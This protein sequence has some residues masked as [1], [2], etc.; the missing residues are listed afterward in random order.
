M[1]NRADL[2]AAHEAGA[3]LPTPQYAVAIGTLLILGGG[4]IAALA[5]YVG[6]LIGGAL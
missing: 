5:C 3:D 1:T 2:R 6:A 4:F